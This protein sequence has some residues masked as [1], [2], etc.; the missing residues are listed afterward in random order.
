MPV[1]S[2]VNIHSIVICANMFVHKDGKVLVIKRSPEKIDLPD[3]IHPIGGKIDASEDPLQAAKR[4]V[5]EEAGITVHKVRLQVVITEV[6]DPEDPQ[7]KQTW[8][9]FD[10]WGDYLSG[11]LKQTDEGELIWLTPD[12]LRSAKKIASMN[13]TI[14]YILNKSA[15]PV[16]ARF[17]YDKYRNIIDKQITVTPTEE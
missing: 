11:E 16:F 8:L 5:M 13:E 2:P 9:I 6:P 4:E 15:E 7:Y 17:Q 12:E 3:V 1:N 10:F 14:E